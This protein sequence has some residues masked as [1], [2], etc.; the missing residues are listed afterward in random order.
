MKSF[1][2]CAFALVLAAQSLAANVVVFSQPPTNSG[3][4]IT[5]SWLPQLGSDSDMYAYDGYTLAADAPVTEVRWRGGYA[6]A[7]A[8]GRVTGFTITF[9]ESSVGGTEP[10]VSNPQLPQIY[11]A[12]YTVPD[13]AGETSAGI[14]GNTELFDYSYT[15]PTPF[16]ATGGVKYWI[17]IE[18]NQVGYPDWGLAFGS[19]GDGSHFNFSTGAARF[20]FGNGDEAFTLLAPQGPYFSVHTSSSSAAEGTTS[21]DGFFTNSASVTVSATANPGYAFV[22]WTENNTIVSTAASYTFSISTNRS[23]VAHFASA[24]TVS[25]G[26]TPVN[27]GTVTGDGSFIYGSTVTLSARP[28]GP[29]YVF[30]NWTEN[31]DPVSTSADYTFTIGANRLL[32]ANFATANSSLVVAYSQPVDTANGGIIKSAWYD[33]NG[34]DGDEYTY[35]SFQTAKATSIVE[36][37]WRGGYTNYKQNAGKSPV[38]NFTIS[39]YESNGGQPN[40]LLAPLAQYN[41]GGNAGE[42]FAGT[43]GGTDMY[44]YDFILPTPFTAQ[45]GVAYWL[46]I[47]ASQGVTPTF[48]W[49][50]DWGFAYGT[51]GNGTHF[52]KLIGGSPAG[53]DAYATISGDTAFTLLTSAADRTITTIA[54]PTNGGHLT[55]GGHYADGATAT[56]TAAPSAGYTFVN[57]NDNGTPVST[58]DSYQFTVAGN[59]TLVAQFARQC[60]ISNSAA[61]A[62]GGTV[63][64]AGTFLSGSDVAVTATPNPGFAFVNWT[65]D[66]MEVSTAS[67]YYFVADTNHNLVANFAAVYSISTLVSPSDSG[68]VTGGGSVQSGTSVSLVPTPKPGYTFVSWNENGAPVCNSPSY[69]FTVTGNRTLTA[70]FAAA[71][72]ITASASSTNGFVFGDGVYASGDS[73]QIAAVPFTG[74]MCSNWSENGSLLTTDSAY[75][76]AANSNRLFNATFVPDTNSVTFDF[77]KSSPALLEGNLTPFTQT[78]GGLSATFDSASTAPFVVQSDSVMGSHLSKFNGNY[79]YPTGAGEIL[80]I[81]FSAP[82][83]KATLTFATLDFQT[84]VVPSTLSVAAYQGSS[85]TQA[86][87]S[88]N[89][90]G[91][92]NA[93]DTM[94]MGTVSLSSATPFDL[95][96][97]QTPGGP[98]FAIDNINVVTIPVLQVS[99]A[100]SN[101]IVLAW[102]APSA[103]F[104]I[105]SCA[106]LTNMTWTEIKSPVETTNGLNRVTLQPSGT[107]AFYKLLVK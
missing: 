2:P 38:Y 25:A 36:M 33:P 15:L 66:G 1:W 71:V 26:V 80:E 69:T 61:P 92:F 11:L 22:N 39:I 96:Q 101:S 28:S 90:T 87:V 37:R 78:S 31:G 106:S 16:Q 60:V 23:L 41:A 105:Q 52:R 107:S 75:S 18:A 81:K 70:V 55:G 58:L 42:T 62:D 86:V 88:T 30:V 14:F 27:S 89:L 83:A 21:G 103:S 56:V 100:V 59:R 4:L 72:S 3:A 49:P 54:S 45:A 63:S 97:I 20:S 64:G 68:M 13:N 91:I 102:P 29:G 48:G 95:L 24:L 51:G 53:G 73:V 44:D 79:L 19:G 17:R 9:Y 50:P 32:M 67:T 35:D 84:L 7:A 47:E 99:Q 5:S 46:Q 10:H 8:F 65:E 74:F 40:I 93:F 77:D 34:L 82:V 12:N 76:F 104:T 6:N 85:A 43:F 57:W 94:P 98:D